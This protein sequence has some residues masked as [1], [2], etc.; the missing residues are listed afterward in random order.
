MQNYS[1]VKQRKKNMLWQ[2]EIIILDEKRIY[3]GDAWNFRET[4]TTNGKFLKT[5]SQCAERSGPLFVK[6][7]NSGKSQ[8]VVLIFK[9]KQKKTKTE[10]NKHVVTH[11]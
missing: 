3:F 10:Q 7:K 5:E 4:K 1:K 8:K 6:K 11:L 2:T 9:T